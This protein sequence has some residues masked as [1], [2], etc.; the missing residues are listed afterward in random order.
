MNTLLPNTDLLFELVAIEP[1]HNEAMYHVIRN[2]LI[3]IGENK[4]GTVFVDESIKKLSDH[5]QEKNQCYYVVKMQG[6]V[7]GGCGISPLEGAPNSNYCELQRMFLLPEAR[8]NG[9]AKELMVK[10]LDFAKSA[11]YTHC[12]LET[13]ESMTRAVSLYR[14][15][16]FEEINGALGNTGHHACQYRMLKAL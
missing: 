13:M 7:V 14:A 15:Y 5:F 4:E 12:Y 11:G 8:G 10:C 16:G 3:E 6:K 2:V 9:A 1:E